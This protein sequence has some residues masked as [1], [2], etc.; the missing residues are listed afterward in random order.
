MED[1][2]VEVLSGVM[3][4]DSVYSA[5]TGIMY[6]IGKATRDIGADSIRSGDII[7]AVIYNTGAAP[8]WTQPEINKLEISGNITSAK[9]EEIQASLHILVQDGDRIKHYESLDCLRTVQA[10]HYA[11]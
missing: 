9:I 7:G 11:P 6:I 5:N 1:M 2:G 10:K 4:L 3:M 8:G